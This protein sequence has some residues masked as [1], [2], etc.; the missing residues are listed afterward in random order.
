MQRF[1]KQLVIFFVMLIVCNYAVAMQNLH[2]KD[3]YGN[4]RYNQA[5]DQESLC[6]QHQNLM[7]KLGCAQN[8]FPLQIQQPDQSGDVVIDTRADLTDHQLVIHD[9]EVSRYEAACLASLNNARRKAL[10]EPCIYGITEMTL[11]GGG[12]ALIISILGVN[13]VGG[14]FA[15][16]TA[17]FDSVRMLRRTIQSGHN[18]ISWPDNPLDTLEER[19][20]LHKRYI[21]RALW[22]KIINAFMSA[23]QSEFSRETHTNFITFALGLTTYKP[24]PAIQVRD[25]RSIAA[26]KNELNKRIDTFF[27]DYHYQDDSQSLNYI[28]INVSKFIDSLIEHKPDQASRHLYF[29]GSG[30]IGKTHLVQ[31]LSRWIDELMP[32]AVRFEDLIISSA[33]QLE[34][35]AERPG[36]F[37]RVLRNQLMENKRGSL[38]MID[39]ATWLN[40]PAMISSAKRI[41]NGDRSK[42]GTSYFGS[43]VDGTGINLEMPPMLVVV[44][45][46][47]PIKNAE[48]KSRFDVVD[49]PMPHHKALVNH[50]I[51]VAHNSSIAKQ[52]HLAVNSN[53][54]DAWIHKLKEKD[55]NFRYVAGNVEAFMLAKKKQVPLIEL[56]QQYECKSE[57]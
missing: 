39:E 44:A 2:S 9:Q 8:V 11:M 31:E 54:I 45:S 38:V 40:D 4:I 37:L 43:G 30:G 49:Y 57:K 23:R 28:K 42:L 1:K 20:A 55:R 33:D 46:N 3:P 56:I 14:N 47:D 13:S 6:K 50:A 26:V 41:F 29:Q 52:S 16:F 10:A 5:F 17:I 32:H 53:E 15:A 25:N 24:K 19:F 36:A 34:G 48:L 22:P 35:N 18:L 7:Q 21:P 27:G 51:K 12:A